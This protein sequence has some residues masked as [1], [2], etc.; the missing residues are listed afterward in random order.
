MVRYDRIGLTYTAT[1]QADPTI[2]AAVWDALGEARS[3]V[4]VGAGAGSYEPRDR[5]V[6]A[7]EP[8]LTMIASRPAGVAAAVQGSAKAL[9]LPDG[10]VDA[11]LA[12]STIHHWSDVRRG[13]AELRRVARR[14]I[15]ILTWDK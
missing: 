10:A 5:Q 7:V 11:A 4:N 2:Q 13:L 9:P 15:V 8:S 12:V 14:K 1:R 6:I 3:V